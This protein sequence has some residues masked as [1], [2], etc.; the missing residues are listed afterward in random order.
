MSHEPTFIGPISH[1]NIKALMARAGFLD[2]QGYVKRSAREHSPVYRAA[3][4]SVAGWISQIRRGTALHETFEYWWLSG[5]QV[6]IEGMLDEY[7]LPYVP[8]KWQGNL[9]FWLTFCQICQFAIFSDIGNSA[10]KKIT[11]FAESADD[12]EY[13]LAMAMG[14]RLCNKPIYQKALFVLVGVNLDFW[15][16]AELDKL[17]DK[18]NQA[19]LASIAKGRK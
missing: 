13:A 6:E 14:D 8:K 15:K 3:S 7:L 2:S 4:N 12:K 19:T 11:E 9:L 10:N 17:I 1:R 18:D 5:P 16:Y